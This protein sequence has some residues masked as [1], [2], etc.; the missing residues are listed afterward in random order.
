MWLRTAFTDWLNELK[1]R[2][3][4][5]VGVAGNHDFVA[6]SGDDGHGKGGGYQL[7][8]DLPWIYLQNQG[9]EVL[10]LNVWGSPY[11]NQFGRWAFMESEPVLETIWSHIPGDV[12][13][14]ITHGPPYG[15]GD[16]VNNDWGDASRD[17]HVGSKSL[18]RI[19]RSLK[20]AI[21]LHVTGHI[22]EAY[23]VSNNGRTAVV[24]ASFVD[25]RYHPRKDA[26][27]IR[28]LRTRNALRSS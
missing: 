8:R 13:I 26:I 2:D 17:K 16:L 14:L 19:V 22:H 1:L 6:Q 7:M 12:D 18:A 21:K 9:Q 24:N 5:V 23:G 4:T 10:G 27:N 3:I 15:H 28:K 20:P 25:E 11:S